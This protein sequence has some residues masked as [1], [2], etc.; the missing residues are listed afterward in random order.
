MA[1]IS[2]YNN[3]DYIMR[4]SHVEKGYIKKKLLNPF[5]GKYDDNSWDPLNDGSS[6]IPTYTDANGYVSFNK[7]SF[8]TFG[9]Y[10]FLFIFISAYLLFFRNI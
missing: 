4:Y 5:P 6:F 7:T 3:R 8:S 1:L 10:G 9:P 2:S